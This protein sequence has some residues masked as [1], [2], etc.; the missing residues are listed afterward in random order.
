MNHR[1]RMSIIKAWFRYDCIQKIDKFLGTRPACY[2]GQWTNNL[3]YKEHY[4]DKDNF[5]LSN[6]GMWGVDVMEQAWNL[7]HCRGLLGVSD[8]TRWPV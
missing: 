7:K 2:K 4:E 3:M 6:L 8:N 1:E 5:W